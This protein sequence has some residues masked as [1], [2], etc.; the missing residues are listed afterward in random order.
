MKIT[1]NMDTMGG[2]RKQFEVLAYCP[3]KMFGY[4]FA[5]HR[6]LDSDGKPKKYGFNVTETSTGCKCMDGMTRKE[7]I[8]KCKKRLEFMGEEALKQAVSS[9]R[10]NIARRKMEVPRDQL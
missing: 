10:Q 3:F 7:A 8:D 1:V 9:G 6:S 5:V 4:I 2:E